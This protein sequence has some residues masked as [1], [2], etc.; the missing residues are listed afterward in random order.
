MEEF[1]SVSVLQ[2]FFS[3]ISVLLLGGLLAYFDPGLFLLFAVS[4]AAYLGWILLFRRQRAAADQHRFQTRAESQQLLLEILQGIAE[5]KL[6]NSELR[7]RMRWMSQQAHVFQAQVEALRIAQWQE[8]GASFLLQ[9]KDLLLT[10]TAATAV[11]H[12]ELTL[13]SL[14]AISFLLG[15]VNLAFQQLTGF[16]RA[17]QDADLS[18]RRLSEIHGD[19]APTASPAIGRPIL[20]TLAP[21]RVDHVSFRYHPDAEDVLHDITFTLEP[22]TVTALVGSSGSGKSTILKLLLQFYTPTAGDIFLGDIPFHEIPGTDWRKLCGAVMQDGFLFS[23][24]IT[25]NIAESEPDWQQPDQAA[26]SAAAD[27]A[28][29]ADFIKRLPLGYHTRLAPRGANLSQGQ[30]QRL[31]IAR[32]LYKNPSLLLFDEATNALD[33]DTEQQINH[34]LRQYFRGRTALVVAH[35]LNTVRDADQIIVLEQ[36]RIVEKGT[37]EELIACK[38]SYFRLV[39]NQLVLEG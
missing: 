8:M 35:R 39:K 28:L 9:A 12:G 15:Q 5:I 27:R 2:T 20:R 37:H 30:R 3:G 33:S 32:A 1:F 6:Q 23:D 25:A 38:G 21:I 4:T 31:L 22:G 34:G 13:G 11:I 10:A 18:F 7:R 36:G 24:S 29:A 19:E 14:L 26:V 16:S 17:A